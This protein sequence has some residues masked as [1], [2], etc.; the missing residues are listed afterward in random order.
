MTK[1]ILETFIFCPYVAD[2]PN[3]DRLGGSE[4]LRFLKSESFQGLRV[5]KSLPEQQGSCIWWFLWNRDQ[6]NGQTA[7]VTQEAEK[8][9]PFFTIQK[10]KVLNYLN[11]IPEDQTPS[12]KQE[13]KRVQLIPV[14]KNTDGNKPEQTKHT[15]MEQKSTN[16]DNEIVKKKRVPFTTLGK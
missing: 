6:S 14:D 1:L 4:F 5:L 13:K 9:G 2:R 3:F 7:K 10:I 11:S 12:P 8:K 15:N 16:N